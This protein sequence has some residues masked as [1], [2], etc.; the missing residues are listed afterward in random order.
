MK[1]RKVEKY[2]RLVW[3]G[4]LYIGNVYNN[5]NYIFIICSRKLLE[6]LI[7]RNNLFS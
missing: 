4:G 7:K 5:G 1:D 3:R 6:V 2:K